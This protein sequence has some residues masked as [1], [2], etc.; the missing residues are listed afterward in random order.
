MVESFAHY[1]I[2][3]RLWVPHSRSCG[4]GYIQGIV[5]TYGWV[6]YLSTNELDESYNWHM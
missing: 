6:Q 5:Q 1:A 3:F 2:H 4:R